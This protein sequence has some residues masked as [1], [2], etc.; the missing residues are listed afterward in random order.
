MFFSC[1][2][3]LFVDVRG[4][5]MPGTRLTRLEIPNA[6]A[7]PAIGQWVARKQMNILKGTFGF[8]VNN[9][10]NTLLI[11]NVSVIVTVSGWATFSIPNLALLTPLIMRRISADLE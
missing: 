9:V 4:I 5:V 8:L 1:V 10:G 3:Q 6:R 2:N 7:K 11:R